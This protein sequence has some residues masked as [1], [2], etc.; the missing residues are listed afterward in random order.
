VERWLA[1]D[2]LKIARTRLLDEGLSEERVVAAEESA[3]DLIEHAVE[4]AR[5]APYPDPDLEQATEFRP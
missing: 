3:R 2:P 5:A 4:T 1:C